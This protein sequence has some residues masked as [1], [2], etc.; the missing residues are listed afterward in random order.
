MQ[1]H[2]DAERLGGLEVDHQLEFGRLLDR[3][4]AGLGALQ[5]LVHVRGSS[6]I[7]VGQHRP[8]AHESARRRKL[9]VVIH[10]GQ[11]VVRRKLHDP[12]LI[13]V[14]QVAPERDQGVNTLLLDGREGRFKVVRSSHL[15]RCKT[16]TQRG[17]GR[18]RLSHPERGAGDVRTPE[19]GHTREL[20]D[21]RFEQVQSLPGQLRSE[22]GQSRDVAAGSP[23]AGRK[24]FPD[25][26]GTH[27]DDG[28]RRRGLAGGFE[29][30]RA[31]GKDHGDLE[32]DQL[33]YE[34]RELADASLRHS[35]LDDDVLSLDVAEL[36]QPLAEC[37][38][39]EVIRSGCQITD[40]RDSDRLLRA[41][42]E[43]PRRRG[44]AEERDELAPPH[45]RAHSI[46]SSARASS[47]SGTVRP[48]ALAV[49]RLIASR[50][51]VGIWTGR[52][53]GVSPLRMRSTY[54][55]ARRYWSTTSGPY[56]VRPPL[57]T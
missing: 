12:S 19:H 11:A 39:A 10:R 37:P 52:S 49:L 16:D 48:S 45:R 44:G 43:R 32:A 7:Q 55:A 9:P 22:V 8:I 33:G 38:G 28:Y 18:D 6:A 30:C 26:I 13:E 21:H 54:P 27:A 23:E 36:A 5:D 56:E 15:D 53:A 46:T 51:L 3:Q 24:S 41:R 47:V 1:R 57:V 25:R 31:A 40:A 29:R 14:D 35:V 50:Y 42:R 20:W 17:S 34:I 4:I 2:V